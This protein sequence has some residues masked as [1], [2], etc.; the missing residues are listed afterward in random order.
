MKEILQHNFTQEL[1]PSKELENVVFIYFQESSLRF[2]K[3]I[4][5]IMILEDQWWST[6][7]IEENI[8]AT[9]I[10]KSID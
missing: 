1:D 8:E 6:R 4:V 7:R 9:P 5:N 10:G 3:S 2:Q